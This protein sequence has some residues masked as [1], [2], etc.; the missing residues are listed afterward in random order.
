MSRVE[1]GVKVELERESVHKVDT[2]RED[3]IPALDLPNASAEGD[4][5]PGDGTEGETNEEK[6]EGDKTEDGEKLK[7]ECNKEKKIWMEYA[8][9]CKCFRSVLLFLF[10]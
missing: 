8:D 5:S 10:L 1:K 2:I 9:F 6:T 7:E 3:E 4:K